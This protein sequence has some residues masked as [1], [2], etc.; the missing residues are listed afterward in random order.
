MSLKPKDLTPEELAAARAAE[1]REKK[2][3][4]GKQIE[5]YIKIRILLHYN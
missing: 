4:R 1:V 2:A 3:G 5:G